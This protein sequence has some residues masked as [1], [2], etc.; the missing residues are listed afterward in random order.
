[1]LRDHPGE[2][3][4][5]DEPELDEDLAELGA[6][7]TLHEE[8]MLELFRRDEPTLDDDVAEPPLCRNFH[9]FAHIGVPL[10]GGD[11]SFGG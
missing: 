2:A 5:G 7:L 10:R 3:D 9:C 4:P 11:P 8:R 6:A 1:L